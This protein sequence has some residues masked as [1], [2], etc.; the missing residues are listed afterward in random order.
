M[1]QFYTD[2]ANHRID[3]HNNIWRYSWQEVDPRGE[4]L[5]TF[6][7]KLVGLSEIYDDAIIEWDGSFDY[8]ELNVK[9]WVLVDQKDH[10]RLLKFYF[11][12][13]EQKAARAL[14]AKQTAAKKVAENKAKAAAKELSEYERLKKK[15]GVNGVSTNTN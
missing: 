12:N 8:F 7:D 4:P 10:A 13:K 2:Y 5:T 11:K 15:Y 14:K 6:I 3:E 9:G 1:E